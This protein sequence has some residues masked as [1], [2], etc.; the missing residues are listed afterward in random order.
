[1]HPRSIFVQIQ[2]TAY[3]PLERAGVSQAS[4]GVLD[5]LVDE[6]KRIDRFG[7]IFIVC[8]TGTAQ[9]KFWD[10]ERILMS[11]MLVRVATLKRPKSHTF[12]W[13]N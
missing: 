2:S 10:V 9:K 6:T 11:P 3:G 13:R 12:V 5:R 1:M 4:E 7:Y 8:A